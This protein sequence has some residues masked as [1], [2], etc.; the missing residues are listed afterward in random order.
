MT[1]IVQYC[2]D[3]PPPKK[4]TKKKTTTTSKYPHN[5]HTPNKIQVSE[6]KNIEIQNF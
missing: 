1:S 2:D 3:P 6:K 4:K 5:R